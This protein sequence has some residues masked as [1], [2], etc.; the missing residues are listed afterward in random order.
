MV[1]FD[2]LMKA[3]DE[4]LRRELAL[5]GAPEMKAD[6]MGVLPQVLRGV[7]WLAVSQQQS[8]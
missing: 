4:N 3:N 6:D 1:R 5:I 8:A 2:N 7:G